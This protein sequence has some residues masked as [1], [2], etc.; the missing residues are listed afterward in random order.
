MRT[1]TDGKPQVEAAGAT[2]RDLLEN[3]EASFPGVRSR[4]CEGDRL[5]PDMA[6][7]VDGQIQIGGL[8]APV[9]SGSEVHF[10]PAVSGG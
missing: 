4:L 2:V 1:L 10:L 7:A 3:L 6:V 5:R 8:R 9:Q